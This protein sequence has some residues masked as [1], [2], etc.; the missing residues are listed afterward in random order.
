M[1]WRIF[2]RKRLWPDRGTILLFYS[3]DWGHPVREPIFGRVSNWKPPEYKCRALLLQHPAWY[4]SCYK[5]LNGRRDSSV[6]IAM[7][8]GL[9]GRGSIPSRARFFSAPQRLGPT[10]APIQWV[11][12]ALPRGW[13]GRGVKLTSH[14]H[15]VPRS[16]MVELCLHSPI[17]FHGIVLNELITGTTL[18]SFFFAFKLLNSD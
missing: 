14:V 1:N 12:G 18:S 8:Y 13:S 17:C 2:E 16:R 6:G 15:L 7:A 11:P 5:L 10:Q 9:D 4:V 3:R